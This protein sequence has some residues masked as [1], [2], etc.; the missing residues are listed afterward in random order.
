MGLELI[1]KLEIQLRRS[2]RNILTIPRGE[3]AHCMPHGESFHT[4]MRSE[5][6]NWKAWTGLSLSLGL[7]VADVSDTHYASHTRHSIH[8]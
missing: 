1:L 2:K 5:S 4:D 3:S 6:E 8:I 7:G